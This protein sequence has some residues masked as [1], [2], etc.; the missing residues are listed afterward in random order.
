MLR[1]RVLLGWLVALVLPAGGIGRAAGNLSASLRGIVYSEATNE[2]IQHASVWL[3]DDGGNRLENSITTDTGEFAFLG[4]QSGGYI[5][6]VSAA[7]YDS[8]DI[9]VNVDFGTERGVSIFLKPTRTSPAN[10]PGSALISAHELSMPEPARILVAAGMK[11]LYAEKNADEALK[12]FQGA[13]EKAPD[14]YE[15]YYQMGMAYLSMQK[16]SDAE[17]NLEKAVELSQQSYAEA[18]VA[19]ARLWIGRRDTAHGEALLR[20]GLELNPKSWMGLFEL[21]KLEL[22]RNHLEAALEAAEKAKSLAPEQP[23]SYRLLS[24]IHLRQKNYT[25]AIAD[26]DGYIRLDP[27]SPEGLTA[28]KILADTQQKLQKSQA[29]GEANSKPE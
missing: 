29:G 7:G 10:I 23:L 2:R 27:N 20:H 3:C 24:L 28:K 9:D 16:S 8:T 22:Y 19:L 14:Y 6:K 25:A 13:I 5:L 17:K 18:D 4:L 26:L 21:G 1:S 15:A 12:D 11:Q